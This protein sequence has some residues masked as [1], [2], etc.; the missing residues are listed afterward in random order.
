MDVGGE[1]EDKAISQ[2]LD[3]EEGTVNLP[4]GEQIISSQNDFTQK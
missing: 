4:L 1:E 3:E 2:V